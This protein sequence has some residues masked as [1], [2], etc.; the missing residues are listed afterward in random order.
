V[1]EDHENMSVTAEAGIRLGT[2]Q[3]KLRNIG[4]G[5]F[6]PL[7]PPCAEEVTLGGAVAAD[8]S[9]P[10]RFKYGTLRDFVLGVEVMIPEAHAAQN[11]IRAGGKTAKNVSGYDMSKL[12]IGSLGTLALITE[13]TCRILP[14][15]EDRATLVAGFTQD[16][17]PWA[18]TQALLES[19]LTPSSIEVYDRHI[20]SL[21]PA[22]LKPSTEESWVAV[23]LEGVTENIERHGAE[24]ERAARSEGATRIVILRG[25]DETGYW[26]QLGRAESEMR[27]REPLSIGFKVSVPLSLAEHI[28]RVIRTHAS[29]L[30]IP[31]FRRAHAGCGMVYTHIPLSEHLYAEKGEALGHTVT[32]LRDEVEKIEGSLVVHYAP[33]A[34]KERV[35]VWGTVGEAFPLM[36]CLK[37]EFDPRGLLNPG[38]YVGGI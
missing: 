5:F 22:K 16:E 13:V 35:D 18:C 27:L 38:R 19:Q 34:F 15:P 32:A 8:A 2:V 20:A 23:G 31:C 28:D 30:N 4:S 12:Y 26:W 33:R 1:D 36:E 9:G 14:V 6:L 24:I 17:A 21:L 25:G 11:K 37:K 10:G 3:E 29:R 7:D